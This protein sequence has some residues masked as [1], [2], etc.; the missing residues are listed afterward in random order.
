MLKTFTLAQLNYLKQNP[1]NLTTKIKYELKKRDGQ[2]DKKD[3]GEAGF[4]GTTMSPLMKPQHV[5]SNQVKIS[6]TKNHS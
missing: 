2:Q 3:G 5:V 6:F 1:S 4:G